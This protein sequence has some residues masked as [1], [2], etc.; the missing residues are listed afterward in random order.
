MSLRLSL[1][2]V[3]IYL[4]VYHVISFSPMNYFEP[5][6]LIDLSISVTVQYWKGR[7]GASYPISYQRLKKRRKEGEIKK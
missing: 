2:S 3:F 5:G 4:S 1:F 6:K 7:R